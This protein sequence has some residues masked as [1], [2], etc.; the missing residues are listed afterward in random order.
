MIGDI[1]K[2]KLGLVGTIVVGTL[3][4]INATKVDQDIL[5]KDISTLTILITEGV[6]VLRAILLTVAF[7]PKIRTKMISDIK[8]MTIHDITRL[9][10][11]A[12]I[13]IILAFLAN[14]V[15]INHGT[16]EVRL[17]QIII[18]LL[19][20]GLIYFLSSN[21]KITTKKIVFFIIL[22]VSAILFS[23]E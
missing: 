18:S 16:N 2:S 14:A 21:K 5:N 1:M 7:I 9:G 22:S 20:T 11:Y 23:M 4:G 17:Y 3:V 6:I 8:K 13:G 12:L 15:L 19:I 10:V